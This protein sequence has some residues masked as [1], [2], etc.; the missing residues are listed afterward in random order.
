MHSTA[1]QVDPQ[2]LKIPGAIITFTSNLSLMII[3]ERGG[4]LVTFPCFWN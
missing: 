1:I 4:L 3:L 2:L